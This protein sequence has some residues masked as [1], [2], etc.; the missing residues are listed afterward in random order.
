MRIGID[1]SVLCNQWD[2]IG[3]Y[4]MEVLSY[5]QNDT[6][7]DSFFLYADRELATELN[8]DNRFTLHI[9][10]GSNHLLWLLT[11]LPKYAKR[12]QLDVFWQPNFILPFRIKGMRNVVSVHDM[13]A[14]A[15][16]EYASVKTNITHKLFL[17]PTCQMAD[18]ILAISNNGAEEIVQNLKNTGSKIQTIYIGKK[19]FENGLDATQEECDRFLNKYN[20]ALENYLLFV[21][22]LSPR[23][24][25]DVIIKGYI[26][27]REHG[28]QKKLVLAGNI[29][30][31][32][33]NVRQFIEDSSFKDDIILTGYVSEKEKRILYYHAAMMLFPSRLEGFG[34]P[35]LEAMQ[36]GIPVIT[37]N[38]SC[39]PEI[40]KDAAVYLNNI[41][42]W[43]E[44]SEHIFEVEN[45]DKN[46]REQILIKGLGR[47]AFFDSQNYCKETYETLHSVINS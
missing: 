3:A 12:D 8:L 17:K 21:G 5:V 20:I 9:D 15:Y 23:K 39:M 27:Y 1:V 47:V 10:K 46:H 42:S 34:F 35:L 32:S 44:L 2:G 25:A 30:D 14:Y 13:S 43:E 37:S 36:A 6:T 45:M 29:A 18:R 4:L 26:E 33:K 38:V 19:M 28:G 40:A 22:T 31:K 41:D 11:K 7:D 24:N 16:S